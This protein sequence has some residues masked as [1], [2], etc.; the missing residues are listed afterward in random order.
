H[1]GEDEGRRRTAAQLNARPQR[2]LHIARLP[3]LR[4]RITI[5]TASSF[6]RD[7]GGRHGKRSDACSE[8]KEEAQGRQG[9]AE[10]AVRLQT[11]ADERHQRRRPD[12]QEE[13][14]LQRSI[15]PF[16]VLPWSGSA[17]AAWLISAQVRSST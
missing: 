8:G 13:L 5:R 15:R 1:Q 17:A 12:R 16:V 14:T 9:Q 10:A 7:L 3:A 4:G 2:I 11:G 6:I